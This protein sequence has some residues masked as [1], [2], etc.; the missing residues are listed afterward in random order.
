MINVSHS[1]KVNVPASKMNTASPSPAQTND[2]PQKSYDDLFPKGMRLIQF[3]GA[4]ET[5]SLEEKRIIKPQ[6]LVTR[7]KGALANAAKMMSNYITLN[8]NDD[9]TLIVREARFGKLDIDIVDKDYKGIAQV[10]IEPTAFAGE[11]GEE[12]HPLITIV[13]ME[14]DDYKPADVVNMIKETLKKE[15]S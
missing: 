7:L 9:N 3:T 11:F 2:S 14:N 5:E 10:L 1:T 6:Y 8:A 15:Y 12:I 13:K 4:K